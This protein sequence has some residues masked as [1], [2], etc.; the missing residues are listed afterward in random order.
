AER[1]GPHHFSYLVLLLVLVIELIATTRELFATSYP[2]TITITSTREA[3][4][5]YATACMSFTIGSQKAVTRKPPRQVVSRITVRW[6]DA[7]SR[8]RGRASWAVSIRAIRSSG[9]VRIAAGGM[10]RAWI[11]SPGSSVSKSA[12]TCSIRPRV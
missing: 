5:G 3:W 1:R 6:I 8:L 4:A 9:A 7:A 2:I 12:A 10:D 11:V